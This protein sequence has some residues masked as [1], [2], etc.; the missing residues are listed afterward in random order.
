MQGENEN[1][2]EKELLDIEFIW[3]A[4]DSFH[5]LLPGHAEEEGRCEFMSCEDGSD[6]VVCTMTEIADE[7]S[8]S[9]GEGDVG[10][11][12]VSQGSQR[13]GFSPRWVPGWIV[14]VRS[15]PCTTL[16]KDAETYQSCASCKGDNDHG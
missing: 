11:H 3:R 9:E 5:P 8:A 2:T 13:G 16:C 10:A 7:L 1:Y 15:H 6:E 12:A 14:F 4:K